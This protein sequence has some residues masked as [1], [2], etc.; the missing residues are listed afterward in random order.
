MSDKK[1]VSIIDH[2]SVIADPRIER[3]KEHKLIDILCIAICS[4]LSGADDFTAME[5]FGHAKEEWLQTFLELPN[6]IPSHDTFGRVFSLIDNQKFCECFTSWVGAAT[7]ELGVKLIAIDGKTSRRSHD[8]SRD[9][10]AIHMVSAFATE[11]GLT[12]GQVKTDE[13]SNEITAIPAL[14]ERLTLSGCIVT[15]DAM[16]C[17]R[18]I[19]AKIADKG[20]DYVL[21]L[22][23]NQ[24]ELHEDVKLFFDDAAVSGFKDT[25]HD[26]YE[27][28]EK[29]HGRIETRRYFATDDIGWLG[30]GKKWRGLKMI[31]MVE[32]ERAIGE[33][34]SVER[35]YYIGSVENNAKVFGVA[36]R[37]HWA[38]ENKLH[39]S[40]DV[41]FREDDSRIRIGNASENMAILRHMALNILRQERTSKR[42]VKTKRLQA[43]WDEGYLVKLL[44]LLKF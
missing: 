21:A 26:Y 8:K 10:P 7:S 28:V 43:G 5:A 35:R 42:G 29:G 44:G 2:F 33:N 40:L 23:G 17:Q 27:T 20:G 36:V 19:A 12:L 13:K 14:L 39:W 41:M 6:G 15:I 18:E 4:T 22:K 11:L 37:N 31:G 38:I 16:G 3:R 34:K 9:K 30:A 24:K 32:S 25:P 1:P